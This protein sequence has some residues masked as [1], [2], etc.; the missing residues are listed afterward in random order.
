M[1]RKIVL[2]DGSEMD[3]PTE[4]E[5]AEL[6][7]KAESAEKPD[8]KAAREKIKYLEDQVAAKN[9]TPPE[10]QPVTL[11]QNQPPQISLDEIRAEAAKSAVKTLLDSRRQTLMASIKDPSQR[12]VAERYYEK[13]V[14]GE[15]VTLETVDKYVQE[16]V[17]LAIP[18]FKT[19]PN[20]SVS[21]MPPIF[22]KDGEA[23]KPKNFADT[24][25]GQAIANDIFGDES[26]AKEASK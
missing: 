17:T 24:P 14:A 10:P 3:I 19:N 9:A 26:F 25:E 20:L 7:A 16:A 21:G 11:P 6:K 13:L 23:G 2:E 4:E 5:L 1:P 18:D 12:Q 8:W 22:E 15:S